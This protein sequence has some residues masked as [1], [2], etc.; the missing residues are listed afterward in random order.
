[1]LL[2]TAEAQTD[3]RRV[4]QERS[5]TFL[6]YAICCTNTQGMG[7]Y[8]KVQILGRNA[9]A[10]MHIRC[11]HSL[12]RPRLVS[13]EFAFIAAAKTTAPSSLIPFAGQA[14]KLFFFTERAHSSRCK[15]IG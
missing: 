5:G 8:I 11:R 14:A 6:A 3:K 4:F 12:L 2:L 13:V 10:H 7:Q 9:T 15:V 1:M